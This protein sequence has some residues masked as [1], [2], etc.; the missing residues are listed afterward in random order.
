MVYAQPG[1]CPGEWY[2]QTSMGLWHSNR[3]PNLGQTTIPNNNRQ[4]KENF[5][6]CALCCL[7]WSQNKTERKWKEK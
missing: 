5:Q 2:T 1:I 6:K 4:K 7:G 3:S